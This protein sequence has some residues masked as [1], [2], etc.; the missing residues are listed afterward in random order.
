MSSPSNR[1]NYGHICLVCPGVGDKTVV[2][3][4]QTWARR[5]RKTFPHNPKKHHKDEAER[6]GQSTDE[7]NSF[8]ESWKKCPRMV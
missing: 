5:Q 2:G 7:N 6:N 1:V 4:P 3:K 8:R